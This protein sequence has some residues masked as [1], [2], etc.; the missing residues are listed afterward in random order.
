M[1][2]VVT[3]VWCRVVCGMVWY[4]MALYGVLCYGVV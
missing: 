3:M 2:I 1:L 4:D